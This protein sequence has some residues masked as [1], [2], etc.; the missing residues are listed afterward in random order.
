MAFSTAPYFGGRYLKK[1]REQHKVAPEILLAEK[2]RIF[3][4][5]GI[6]SPIHRYRVEVWT[7]VAWVHVPGFRPRFIPLSAV[8]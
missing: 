6:Y 5:L 4:G 2:V 8:A 3:L 7:C 1:H